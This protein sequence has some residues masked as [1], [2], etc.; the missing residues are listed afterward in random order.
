MILLMASVVWQNVAGFARAAKIAIGDRVL[1]TYVDG[2]AGHCVP[3][4]P[5]GYYVITLPLLKGLA[6]YQPDLFLLL[7]PIPALSP[8]QHHSARR[9]VFA[10]NQQGTL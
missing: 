3:S 7:R 8:S 10:P 4:L 2:E 5:Q 1:L 9:H 6:V